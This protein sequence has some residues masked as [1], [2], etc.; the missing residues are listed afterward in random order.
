M[1]KWYSLIDKVYQKDNLILASKQVRRNHRAPGIA[2]F[3]TI[4]ILNRYLRDWINYY[5]VANIKG[6]LRK[7]MSW[8]RRPLRMK[9]MKWVFCQLCITAD[10]K[11]MSRIRK[12]YGSVRVKKTGVIILSSSY[13]IIFTH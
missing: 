1:R 6:F 4:Q 13:S 9:R 3:V 5:R 7:H 12:K 11:F 2:L 8:I 10:S